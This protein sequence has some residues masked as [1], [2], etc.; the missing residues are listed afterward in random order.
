MV[1]AAL[2]RHYLMHIHQSSLKLGLKQWYIFISLCITPGL[3]CL[4]SQITKNDVYWLYKVV[5]CS[6]VCG[7]R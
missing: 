6:N 5:K 7:R 4:V 2:D 1:V 3:Y